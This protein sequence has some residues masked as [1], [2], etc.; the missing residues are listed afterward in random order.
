MQTT[1]FSELFPLFKSASPETI[2]WLLSVSVERDYPAERTV[3]M[4]DAWGNAVY[5]IAAGWIKVRR[6]AGK[7]PLTLAILGKGDF[8][9]EMAVLDELPRSTDVVA[10]SPV[11]LLSVP[12]QFFTEALHKDPNLHY[13]MLQLMVK[14]LR[15]AN[16]RAQLRYESPAVKL[17]SLLVTLAESYGTAQQ[18]EVELF[19]LPL[20]DLADV[21][22]ISVDEAARLMEKLQSK[23]WIQI[24][25]ALKTLK[26]LQPRQL[27]QLA[28]HS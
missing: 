16:H 9:G 24:D 13:R 19:N 23:G 15:Q 27:A 10:F 7:E 1:C 22:D 14:R 5:L 17:A 3:L 18:K 6:L 20:R 25:P 12:A 26:L 4:E 8:F 11:H 2:D 28:S 21:S